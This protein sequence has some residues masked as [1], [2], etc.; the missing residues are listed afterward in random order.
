[1]VVFCETHT[2]ININ[3]NGN[4][5]IAPFSKKNID[6]DKTKNSSQSSTA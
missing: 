6:T 5:F 1:M 3:C 2:C 4:S